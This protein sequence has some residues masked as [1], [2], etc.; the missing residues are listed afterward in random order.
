MRKG[1]ET[2][3][4]ILRAAEQLFCQKGYEAASMQEIV[5]AA[6]VS[7]GGIYHH[8]ASKEEIM[9]L[10]S[11]QHAQESAER[12]EAQLADAPDDLAPMRDE[13]AA[14]TAMLLPMATSPEGRAMALTYL[15]ALSERFHPLL[16]QTIAQGV[17][18]GAL[19]TEIR[20]VA[21]I[22]LHL[23]G[24]CFFDLAAQLMQAKN[25]KQPCDLPALVDL[26]TR[27]RRAVEVLLNAPFGSVTLLTLEDVESMAQR[28]L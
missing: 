26:L 3:R 23:L 24:D 1:D 18:S 6:G 2:K 28:L 16:E 14:F 21:G 20:G 15:D 8:F 9:T 5:R 19:F 12:A 4:E 13:D 17:Q 25:D 22:V 11:H 7:K 27:Y 10:L